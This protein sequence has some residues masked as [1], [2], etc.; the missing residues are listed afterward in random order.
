MGIEYRLNYGNKISLEVN[1]FVRQLKK[2]KLEDKSFPVAVNAFLR[3]RGK[4]YGLDNKYLPPDFKKDKPNDN[5]PSRP[6]D[7]PTGAV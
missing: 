6:E 1:E 5:H 7:T 2:F 4:H 3:K